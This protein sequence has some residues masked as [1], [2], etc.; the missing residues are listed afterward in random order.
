MDFFKYAGDVLLEFGGE[1]PRG[2]PCVITGTVLALGSVDDRGLLT[3]IASV[4][5]SHQAA[6]QCSCWTMA[7]SG[8]VLIKKTGDC[9]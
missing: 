8:L 1:L 3:Q 6:A 4:L 7:N 9:S 2:L 5:D